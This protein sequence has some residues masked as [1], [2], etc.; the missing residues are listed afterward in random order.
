VVDGIIK[1][2]NI[3]RS[4]SAKGTPCDNAV[5]ESMYNVLKTEMVFGEAFD[6]LD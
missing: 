5:A 6:T 3:N 1:A 2:F 4:L